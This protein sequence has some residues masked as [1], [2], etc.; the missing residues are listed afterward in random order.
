M[1]ALE[2]RWERITG[3]LEGGAFPEFL[4]VYWNSRNKLVRKTELFKVI[5]RKITNKGEVI[6]LIRS[7]D[8]H[9]DIY[10]NTSR[11]HP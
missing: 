2:D 5:Q 4:R 10:R 3:V 7:L 1:K 6:S 11:K 9:A 8:T